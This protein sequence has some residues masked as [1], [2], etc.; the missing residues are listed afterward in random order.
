MG[1]IG[2]EKPVDSLWEMKKQ[3]GAAAVVKKVNDLQL[4]TSVTQKICNISHGSAHGLKSRIRFQK[5]TK[6]QRDQDDKSK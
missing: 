5:I 4:E 3:G 2:K 6:D 1:V